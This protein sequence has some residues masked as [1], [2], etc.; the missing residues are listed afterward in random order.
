MQ[1]QFDESSNETHD[2]LGFVCISVGVA[3]G[4]ASLATPQTPQVGPHLVPASLLHC[5]TLTAPLHEQ[6]L[7]FGDVTHPLFQVSL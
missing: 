1:V 6:L 7:A 4:L 2:P 3:L 5:V